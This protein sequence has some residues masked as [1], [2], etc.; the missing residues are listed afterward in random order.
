M[1][2]YTITADM[3]ID[4]MNSVDDQGVYATV[5]NETYKSGTITSVAS[6]WNST[7]GWNTLSKDFYVTSDNTR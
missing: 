1:G 7:E 5:G 6:T 3:R 4:N 2:K